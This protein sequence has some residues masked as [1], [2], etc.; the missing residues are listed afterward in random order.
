MLKRAHVKKWNYHLIFASS[1]ATCDFPVRARR[2]RW[3]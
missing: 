2:R 1:F 3:F